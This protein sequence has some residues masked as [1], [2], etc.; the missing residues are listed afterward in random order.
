MAVIGVLTAGGDCPGL[1]AVIRAVVR[2]A[3]QS[4]CEVVGVLDGWK[5]LETGVDRKAPLSDF[6]PSDVIDTLIAGSNNFDRWGFVQGQ[7][8]LVTAMYTALHVPEAI[9]N[10]LDGSQTPEEAAADLQTDAEN[11]LS[12]L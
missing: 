5:G 4:G 8:E 12:L 6:Y 9:G 7:G 10:I 2:R 11:E 3:E 1:N